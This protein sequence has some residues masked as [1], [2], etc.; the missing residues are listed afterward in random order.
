MAARITKT[1]FGASIKGIERLRKR[2]EDPDA[3]LRQVGGILLA[4]A[5]AAF[6]QQRLGA[7]RWSKRYPSQ[8]PPIIN[9]AG[10]LS[11]FRQGAKAPKS[12]RFQARPAG[13][14][15]GHLKRSIAVS[16]RHNVVEVGSVVPYA[17]VIQWGGTSTQPVTGD[18]KKRL[19]KWMATLR[20]KRR[21]V[22]TYSPSTKTW[23]PKRAA[24][25]K[26]AGKKGTPRKS[27]KKGT[28]TK[29]FKSPKTSL[30]GGTKKKLVKASVDIARAQKLGF[31]FQRSK[32][33]T[34][35]IARPFLGLTPESRR[36]IRE[37][38]TEGFQHGDR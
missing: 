34:K 26:K 30:K 19:A 27:G 11:D 29:S 20:G 24:K 33:K 10:A 12:D 3:V 32:L 21:R 4:Q 18:A 13:V 15:T 25:S 31:L 14:D 9:V 6:D 38:V 17:S 16:I 37:I 23:G 22:A 5:H 7:T 1:P 36:K 8:K 2:L 35:V 28:P